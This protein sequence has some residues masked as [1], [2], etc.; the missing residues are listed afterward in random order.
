M[1]YWQKDK[2][3]G[4]REVETGQFL[5]SVYTGGREGFPV[6]V[7]D[8]NHVC[9]CRFGEA[10]RSQFDLA[11][12]AQHGTKSGGW[13]G[14]SHRYDIYQSRSVPGVYAMRWWHGGGQG[15]LVDKKPLSGSVSVLAIISNLPSENVR[16]DCCHTIAEA[17]DKT[18]VES[19]RAARAS[20]FAAFCEKRLKKRKRGNKYVMEIVPP[21]VSAT[22]PVALVAS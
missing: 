9:S 13:S 1:S 19:A 7:A 12:D 18:A 21:P 8:W 17:I 16:W 20:I 15:W 4:V 5:I 6:K 14:D 2:P 22:E 10:R 3:E 11:R